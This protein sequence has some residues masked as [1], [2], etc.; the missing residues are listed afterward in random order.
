VIEDGEV[1]ETDGWDVGYAA[2]TGFAFNYDNGLMHKGNQLE[3]AQTLYKKTVAKESRRVNRKY[4]GKSVKRIT[5]YYNSVYGEVLGKYAYETFTG[6]IKGEVSDRI[7][8]EASDWIYET[9]VRSK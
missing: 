6:E 8:E 3:A 5:S 1:N 2:A 9:V 7:Y 4:A